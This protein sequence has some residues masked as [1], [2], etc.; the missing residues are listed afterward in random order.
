MRLYSKKLQSVKELQQERA[1]LQR[2]LRRM[3]EED[4]LDPSA[5]LGLG[6]KG[7]KDGG[8]GIG[9]L[10]GSIPGS[11][12]IITL[13]V[14]TGQRRFMKQD[15]EVPDEKPGK[16]QKQ[17]APKS[18]GLLARAAYEFIGGYLKWK[19]IELSYKGIRYLIKKKRTPSS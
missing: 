3:D 8:S 12:K 4:F 17:A 18:R 7:S 13:I 1:R 19:A 14:E 6:S 16:Q 2:K 15:A 10:L 5:L 11:E 9:S